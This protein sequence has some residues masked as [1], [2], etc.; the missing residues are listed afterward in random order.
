MLIMFTH[1]I[2]I[3]AFFLL[4][5]LLPELI[6]VLILVLIMPNHSGLNHMHGPLQD[7]H[8]SRAQVEQGHVRVW[9]RGTWRLL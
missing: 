2:L 3:L 4:L 5:A 9:S 7:L 1:L 6:L 8:L